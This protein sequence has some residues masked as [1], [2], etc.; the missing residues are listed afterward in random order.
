MF[1]RLPDQLKGSAMKTVLLLTPLLALSHV[2]ACAADSITQ[3]EE[4]PFFARR[5]GRVVPPPQFYATKAAV[6]AGAE[7]RIKVV[8]APDKARIDFHHFLGG[9]VFSKGVVKSFSDLA[10]ERVLTFKTNKEMKIGVTAKI[11]DE[12]A[13][14]KGLERKDG[15]DVLKYAAGKQEVVVEVE[16]GKK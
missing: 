15:K 9:P 8:R 12:A 2:A 13:T 14:C 1:R 11:G 7:V 6:P 3:F 16:V 4:R 5:L 10:T